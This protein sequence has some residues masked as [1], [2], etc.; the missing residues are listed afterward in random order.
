MQST[1]IRTVALMGAALLLA[2]A[3]V[4]LVSLAGSLGT[5]DGKAP[6]RKAAARPSARPGT[7]AVRLS[8]LKI[9]PAAESAAAGKTTFVATNGGAIR[10]ELVVIRTDKWAG[11]LLKGK[12]A[13]EAGAVDEIGDLPSGATKR[14]ALNLKPGHYALICNLPG[15]YKGGMFADFTVR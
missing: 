11:G 7:I 9:R 4:G 5:N 12:E 3:A 6:V 10:H 15:H 14:L 2:A 8:E 13:S 1:R